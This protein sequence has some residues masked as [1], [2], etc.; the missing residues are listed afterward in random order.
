MAHQLEA[1]V[2]QERQDV[3]A[4]AGE[5]IVDAQHLMALPNQRLAQMRADEARAARHQNPPAT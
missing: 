2:L 4:R 1:A 5:E 3:L